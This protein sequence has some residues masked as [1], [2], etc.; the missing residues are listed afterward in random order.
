MAAKMWRIF[1]KSAMFL[2]TIHFSRH[3]IIRHAIRTA[4]S[5]IKVMCASYIAMKLSL[6]P[7]QKMFGEIL[8]NSYMPLKSS[9]LSAHNSRLT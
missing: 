8:V 4:F 6:M 5:I 7:Q 3:N 1:R 9:L 2:T